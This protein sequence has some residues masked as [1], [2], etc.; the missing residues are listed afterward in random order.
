V[1]E[2]DFAI[3][4][5]SVK[6]SKNLSVGLDMVGGFYLEMQE[7]EKMRA[8][9]WSLQIVRERR[10]LNTGSSQYSFY[11]RRLARRAPEQQY[12]LPSNRPCILRP[13]P[14]SRY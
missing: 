5:D 11:A 6:A 4:N 2:F 1:Q 7:T 10:L 14:K 13:R 8:E 9:A 3:T 12:P